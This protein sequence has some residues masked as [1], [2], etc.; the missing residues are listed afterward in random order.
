MLALLF[1]LLAAVRLAHINA[2]PPASLHWGRGAFTDESFYSHNARSR[3]LFGSWSADGFKYFYISPLMSAVD[4]TA[5]KVGGVN[6]RS[7]RL[8][9]M[10]FGLL[11]VWLFYLWAKNRYTGAISLLGAALF[12]LNYFFLMHSRMAFSEI[13][14]LAFLMASLYSLDR[15]KA[16][17]TIWAGIFFGLAVLSKTLALV[18]GPIVLVWVCREQKADFWRQAGRFAGGAA[19]VAVGLWLSLVKQDP[20]DYF[21]TFHIFVGQ[22]SPQHLSQLFKV[23]HTEYFAQLPV[24]TL[25]V[26]GSLVFNK[27]FS[28]GEKRAAWWLL[29]GLGYLALWSYTTPAYFL[30][31]LIPMVILATGLLSRIAAGELTAA[32]LPAW[33]LVLWLAGGYF[34]IRYIFLF[35]GRDLFFAN[36]AGKVG[37]EILTLISLILVYLFT[38][39]APGFKPRMTIKVLLT[40]FIIFD[41]SPYLC[42]LARPAYTVEAAASDIQQ[43]VGA[44]T[45]AGSWAPALCLETRV[46]EFPFWENIVNDRDLTKAIPVTHLLL[47]RNYFDLDYV[48][49][50]YPEILA[51]ARVEKTY[52]IDNKF[53]DLWKLNNDKK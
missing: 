23:F 45:V 7:L 31:L 37:L 28:S 12:G 38:R 14:M 52:C 32:E 17:G 50:A 10:G 33:Q 22:R 51:R 15:E 16:G 3:V 8:A 21:N 9:S 34:L 6:Y 19:L 30:I 41:F 13:P 5:F 25:L 27:G 40:L 18:F 24:I 35:Y 46:R 49:R 42:W 26:L 2:D 44:G 43:K 29:I 11:T 36:M 48:Q 20:A 1:I 53:I 47:E 39:K 4:Y